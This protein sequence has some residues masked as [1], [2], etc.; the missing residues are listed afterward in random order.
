MPRAFVLP[1]AVLVLAAPATALRPGPLPRALARPSFSLGARGAGGGGSGG[2][3]GGVPWTP[4]ENMALEDEIRRNRLSSGHYRWHLILQNPD[5]ED[6]TPAEVK[7]RWRELSGNS[8][9]R[10]YEDLPL[11]DKWEETADGIFT[12]RVYY[13]PDVPDGSVIS[14]YYVPAQRRKV[15]EGLIETAEGTLYELGKPKY[16]AAQRFAPLADLQP[17][18]TGLLAAAALGLFLNALVSLIPPVGG[19]FS[20]PSDTQVR[21]AFGSLFDDEDDAAAP[22][23]AASTRRGGRA[24]AG[25]DGLSPAEQRRLKDLESRTARQLEDIRRTLGD[26]SLDE[27][28]TLSYEEL[29]LLKGAAL[30][31]GF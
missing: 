10:A 27:A 14:T 30:K 29:E 8:D 11:L 24:A 28:N 25:T 12:G 19:G 23:P 17:A 7:A 31:Q 1:L 2:F 9:A 3:S 22:A 15:D 13:L 4:L 16:G 18:V 20:P 6:R 21:A 5:L 26:E